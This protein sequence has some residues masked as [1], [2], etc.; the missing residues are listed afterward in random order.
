MFYIFHQELFIMCLPV[1]SSLQL[2][3]LAYPSL[4]LHYHLC[5]WGVKTIWIVLETYKNH[6]N[7]KAGWLSFSI[8]G[9]ICSCR[10]IWVLDVVK[11]KIYFYFLFK[12]LSIWDNHSVVVFKLL[13]G[14]CACNVLFTTGSTSAAR[15]ASYVANGMRVERVSC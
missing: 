4:L 8:C 5:T 11:Q 12:L 1:W 10:C 14:R 6:T 9:N 7:N 13:C 15:L 2:S 3:N